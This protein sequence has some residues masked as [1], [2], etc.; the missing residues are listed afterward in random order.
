M[1]TSRS[2]PLSDFDLN[3]LPKTGILESNGIPVV[4]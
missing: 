4:P 3:K 1:I 2:A